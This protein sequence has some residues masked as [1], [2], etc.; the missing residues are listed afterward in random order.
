M[1]LSVTT[2][3]WVVQ[4]CFDGQVQKLSVWNIWEEK[5][6]R[7]EGLVPLIGSI[8]HFCANIKGHEKSEWEISILTTLSKLLVWL[9][10]LPGLC[11]IPWQSGA[12]SS[13]IT[14]IE[15]QCG[16]SGGGRWAAQQLNSYRVGPTVWANW[17]ELHSAALYRATLQYF[18]AG[19]TLDC[20]K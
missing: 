8:N 14:K 7:S 1:V 4:A 17:R 5:C 2:Q 15:G 3:A 12:A 13:E 16:L 11:R 19:H 18:L 20:T 10:I 6:S 9:R